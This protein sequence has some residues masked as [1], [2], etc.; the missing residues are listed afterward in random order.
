MVLC[1]VATFESHSLHAYAG[2][3]TVPQLMVMKTR[4]ATRLPIFTRRERLH[5]RIS[6]SLASSTI[7]IMNPAMSEKLVR[8]PSRF[9]RTTLHQVMTISIAACLLSQVSVQTGEQPVQDLQAEYLDLYLM[10][11]PL[12]GNE[13]KTVEPPIKVCSFCDYKHCS[14]F[15]SEAPCSMCY[16][17]TRQYANFI[18]Q[19]L[20]VCTH[21]LCIPLHALPDVTLIHRGKTLLQCIQLS[22]G[23]HA[24]SVDTKLQGRHIL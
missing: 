5:A 9:A 12:T 17:Q 8:R 24:A 3:S 18:Y 14:K 10:H 1:A 22:L 13:G 15:Q 6:G 19:C 2:T 16:S 21:Q 11:W 4:S 7:L 20:F 23:F